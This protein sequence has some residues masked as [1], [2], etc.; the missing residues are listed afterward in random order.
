MSLGE[1][2]HSSDSPQALVHPTP[3]GSAASDPPSPLPP[4]AFT[5]DFGEI[6]SRE[7]EDVARR[8][9]VVGLPA[10]PPG[11]KTAD[12]LAGLAFS[13]GGVRSASFN[14]GLIQS[15]FQHGLLRHLDY[16]ATISGGGYIGTYLSTL[17]RRSGARMDQNNV[18]L[19]TQLAE[20]D[21][22]KQPDQVVTFVR[23][24]K[25]LGRLQTFSNHYFIGLF[26]N[27]VV[28][29]SGLVTVCMG[30][31]YLW[32]TTSKRAAARPRASPPGY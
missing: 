21:G 16:L 13:G 17:L 1:D 14:L 20:I 28:F 2:P 29:V 8:R 31:A 23:N 9:K 30:I 6:F 25:Y 11:K 27:N 3:D 24:G 7:L 5:N 26:L 22:A 4:S 12:N 18:E 32:R 10:A 19:R 15:F